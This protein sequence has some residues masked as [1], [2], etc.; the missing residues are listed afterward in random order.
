MAKY[1][2]QHFDVLVVGAGPAGIAA[3]VRAAEH[4]ARVGVVDDNLNCGGQI[5]RGAGDESTEDAAKW[6][7]SF[8]S[9][10]VTRLYG[11]RVFHQPEAGVL[12]VE[13]GDDLR[14]LRYG[15]LVLA[16]G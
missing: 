8:R 16:T 13:G 5:W 12:W 11:M 1:S 9:A 14:E 6:I 10:N 15:N 3:T 7:R 2:H 4:G